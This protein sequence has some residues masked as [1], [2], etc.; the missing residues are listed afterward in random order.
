MKSLCWARLRPVRRSSSVRTWHRGGEG[1]RRDPPTPCQN[2][3]PAPSTH[4]LGGDALQVSGGQDVTQQR[5]HRLLR[6]LW[7]RR[8]GTAT[9]PQ[10]AP[11]PRSLP[12]WKPR[13]QPYPRGAARGRGLPRGLGGAGAHG[14]QVGHGQPLV[15]AALLRAQRGRVVPGPE[16][17]RAPGDVPPAGRLLTGSVQLLQH[18]P[19]TQEPGTWPPRPART[20]A[21]SQDLI[22]Q[23]H[24]SRCL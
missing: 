8:P 2:P 20:A 5:P 9:A 7:H 14:L 15:E 11:P 16:Q 17:R 24:T 1:C 13:P 22:S 12:N 23:P 3:P 19:A 6:Q 21:S 18:G 4:L 10:P